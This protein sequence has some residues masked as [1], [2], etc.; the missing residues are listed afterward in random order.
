MQFCASTSLGGYMASLTG[1]F[2]CTCLSRNA[3]A[4][5]IRSN[6]EATRSHDRERYGRQFL[7]YETFIRNCERTISRYFKV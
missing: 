4:I 1:S 2:E 6:R 5:I 7:F 3:Y